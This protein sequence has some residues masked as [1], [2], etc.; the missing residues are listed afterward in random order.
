MTNAPANFDVDLSFAERARKLLERDLY[1]K[2]AWEGRFCAIGFNTPAS[3]SLQT[4]M[5]MDAIIQT[6]ENT[7]VCVEE[8]LVRI[9]EG[10][11]PYTAFTLETHSD[12]RSDPPNGWMYT[13]GA[14]ILLYAFG[15]P[16]GLTV[17]TMQ[18]DELRNWFVGREA[19]FPISDTRNDYKG[20][21]WVTRCR[22][23]PIRAIPFPI[24]E[25]HLFYDQ[26]KPTDHRTRWPRG[27]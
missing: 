25:H 24:H 7:S 8:K 20:Q 21:Q 1:S 4:V 16:H 19:N 12:L 15:L 18:M 10:K 17:W 13:C 23:V 6:G 2:W 5:H 9:P 3:R 27:E 14:D 11:K 26:Q 22:V